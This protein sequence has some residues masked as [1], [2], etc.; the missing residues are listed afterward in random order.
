MFEPVTDFSSLLAYWRRCSETCRADAQRL[1]MP[2]SNELARDAAQYDQSIYQ[3]ETLLALTAATSGGALQCAHNLAVALHRKHY[4]KDAPQ[5][6]PCK[7]IGGLL[8]QIDNMTCGMER[9]A[10]ATS[11]GVGVRFGMGKVIVNTG[12]HD[13]QPA[14]FV[15]E[16]PES[17]SVGEPAP[18]VPQGT[19]PKLLMVFPTIEQAKR[20]ADALVD[21]TSGGANLKDTTP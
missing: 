11:G 17:G 21:G 20:V 19:A 2:I 3:V 9:Q 1:G 6:E 8:S 18:D 4:A 14:V 10:A 16:A 7:D 13:G 15:D 5:W 12:T